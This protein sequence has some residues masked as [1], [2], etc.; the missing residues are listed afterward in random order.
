MQILEHFLDEATWVAYIIEIEYA[1]PDYI[2]QRQ[3]QGPL[4]PSGDCFGG[5]IL[6]KI[7][8]TARCGAN[9]NLI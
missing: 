5:P 6:L 4:N 3:R 7:K 9:I 1:A 2:Q 8:K